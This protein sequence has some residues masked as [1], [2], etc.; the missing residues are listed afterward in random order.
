MKRIK[1]SPRYPISRSGAE[2]LEPLFALDGHQAKMASANLES[3]FYTARPRRIFHTSVDLL[4]NK[5]SGHPRGPKP[6]K[7]H[8]SRPLS[9]ES[10]TSSKQPKQGISAIMK[11]AAV[12]CFGFLVWQLYGLTAQ[13]LL[14]DTSTMDKDQVT[15]KYPSIKKLDVDSVAQYFTVSDIFTFTPSARE[16]VTGCSYRLPL[17][18]GLHH[19]SCF[20]AFNVRKYFTQIYMCYAFEPPEDGPYIFEDIRSAL[21]SPGLFFEVNLNLTYC[22]QVQNLRVTIHP[23]NGLPRGGINFPAIA[24]RNKVDMKYKVKNE[25]IKVKKMADTFTFTYA[26]IEKKFQPPPFS[27]C[28][29]YSRKGYSS[30]QHCKDECLKR[31]VPTAMGLVPFSPLYE[32]GVPMKVVAPKNIENETQMDLLYAIKQHCA[33][34]CFSIDCEQTLFT[35]TS[36]QSRDAGS[37]SLTFTVYLKDAPTI[38][39]SAVPTQDLGTFLIGLLGCFGS[40]FDCSFLTLMVLTEVTGAILG[41]CNWFGRDDDGH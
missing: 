3:K 38:E 32:M 34:E 7:G 6:G 10:G 37:T 15:K 31:E 11:M 41:K 22:D 5:N 14:Y 39:A 12:G 29:N 25:T 9:T 13:Y 19:G 4:P 28:I 1:Q 23:N 30:Q 33:A 2:A 20:E 24:L 27:N 8:L 21:Y 35:T 16:L 26:K 40:W 18:F 36:I 17:K